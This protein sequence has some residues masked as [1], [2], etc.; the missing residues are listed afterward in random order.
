[1]KSDGYFDL[2]HLNLSTGALETTTT[3]PE[4]L[5]VDDF[6]LDLPFQVE[7]HLT[8]RLTLTASYYFGLNN[9]ISNDI[10]TDY[11]WRRHQLSFGARFNL[12]K[13]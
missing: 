2:T 8:S 12:L 1:V 6:N 3:D 9:L 7:Y 5:D 4:T 10:E 13:N 11:V